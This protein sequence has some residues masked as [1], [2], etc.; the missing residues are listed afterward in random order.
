MGIAKRVARIGT[1]AHHA[2]EVAY[3]KLTKAARAGLA[4]DG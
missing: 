4:D 1:T 3:Q 2:L